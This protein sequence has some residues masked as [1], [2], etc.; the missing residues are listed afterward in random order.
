MADTPA[1]DGTV[2]AYTDGACTGNP[3]PAGWGAILRF[4]T[5]V[6]E[7]SGYLGRATNNIAELW[8]IKATL[9]AV[10]DRSMPVRIY[11]DSAYSLGILTRNWKPKANQE[12]V[13]EIRSLIAEFDRVEVLKVAG[14]AGI[15]DN[16]KA[17]ELARLAIP[18]R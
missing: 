18:G 12:L 9:E 3:G 1:P 13:A 6:R 15:P 7:L 16:E 8:A 17:D 14:H 11:T 10:T 4:G 2:V 5:H